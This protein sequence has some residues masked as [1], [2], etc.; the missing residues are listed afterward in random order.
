MRTGKM[1]LIASAV[2]IIA[3]FSVSF[4]HAF[5][6]GDY[7]LPVSAE[8]KAITGDIQIDDFSIRFETGATMKFSEL[9]AETFEVDG[10]ELPASVYR[11]AQPADPVL[12]GGKH[13]CG[14][15]EVSYIVYWMAVPEQITIGVFTDDKPPRND[16]KSCKAYIYKNR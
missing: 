7:Y 12:K 10:K 15:G 16:A 6:A 5:T 14:K 9:V 11:V 1:K 4:A 8:A 2:T 13:L 3:L